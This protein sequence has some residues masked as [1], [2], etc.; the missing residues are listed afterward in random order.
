MRQLFTLLIATSL[1]AIAA[2]TGAQDATPRTTPPN[3]AA[4]RLDPVATGFAR[5]LHV[6]SANDGTGRL[7]VVQQDGLIYVIEDG[8]RLETPFLDVS[9]EISPEAMG[10][11]Y[12]E[13]G[14]LGLTFHPNYATNGQFFINYTEKNS[15]DSILARYTV[16]SNHNA[17][18]P[19]SAAEL[20]R[21]SQPY[22]NHNGGHIAF[23]PDGYLYMSLGDGGS[24][25]DP[26]NNGQQATT[27]LGAIVRI[28]V[29]GGSPYA[30]P[31]DNPFADGVNGVPE[32]WAYGLRNVW[33][34]SFDRLTG[35]MY[36][37]DVGQN[38]WEEINFQP[39]GEGGQNYGW[40][41]FE[42]NYPYSGA[43]ALANAVMPVAEYQHVNGN[44]SV[45]GGFV[46]RGEEIEALQG[47]YIYGDYCSGQLWGT[48]R[49]PDGTW[50]TNPL[51]DTPYT[52]SSFGEDE[53]G[54]LYLVHYGAGNLP[55]QIMKFSAVR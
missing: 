33:R 55:G 31:A 7:F 30:V 43:A 19:T 40:N 22:A 48:Y 50:Q 54:E 39:A 20:M 28:D 18:D 16:S 14:L 51:V 23:G 47:A 52:I 1:L 25:G 49:T 27:L 37:G 8:E 17:A 29:D 2:V 42:A 41:V 15:N 3:P 11:G 38:R 46:Y 13:R 32:V 5:A 36:L 4:F 44:C 12:S 10:Q 35:D 24:A 26:L 53:N 6:T 45:T 9:G 34:F 21:V